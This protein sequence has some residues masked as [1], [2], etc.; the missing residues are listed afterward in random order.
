MD[1]WDDTTDDSGDSSSSLTAEY[2]RKKQISRLT[3]CFPPSLPSS[4]GL[5]GVGVVWD[6]CCVDVYRRDEIT[7]RSMKGVLYLR[8]VDCA[9]LCLFIIARL[10]FTFVFLIPR[11]EGIGGWMGGWIVLDGG[12]AGKGRRG[13][14]LRLYTRLAE[15]GCGMVG[16]DSCMD[17]TAVIGVVNMGNTKPTQ[18]LY[19]CVLDCVQFVAVVVYPPTYAV[20][21]ACQTSV[22][23]ISRRGS[24]QSAD[25]PPNSCMVE[26][27][28]CLSV[29]AL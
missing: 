27:S 11:W 13:C 20:L 10:V 16:V 28:I 26:I 15:G 25:H 4:V 19:C 7:S 23:R 12:K 17:A 29:D 6:G 21:Q 8:C 14:R 9:I 24:S 18:L 1:G 2:E 5:G 22:A 3:L